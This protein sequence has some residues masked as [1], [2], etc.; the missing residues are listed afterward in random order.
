MLGCPNNAGPDQR[1]TRRRLRP[2]GRA[3]RRA[4]GRMARRR[5]ARGP[6]RRARH[7]RLRPR[8]TRSPAARRGVAARALRLAGRV[9]DRRRADGRLG[10]R[11]RPTTSCC[12]SGTAACGGSRCARCASRA[13]T[14][15]RATTSS[16]RCSIRSWPHWPR[17]G[18]GRR[19][20]SGGPPAIAS[21]RPSCWAGAAYGDRERA[22]RVGEAILAP[23]SPMHVP[24]RTASLDGAPVHVRS[25]CCLYHRV[26]GAEGARV[27]AAGLAAVAR[28]R[29]AVVA[30]TSFAR[31][32]EVNGAGRG[33]R[34]R[35]G[36][37]CAPRRASCERLGRNKGPTAH[38]L[39][40]A[41]RAFT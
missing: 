20:R 6:H 19:S 32:T 13:R 25:S 38:S 5:R 8:R 36:V 14:R 3:A 1:A 31:S 2:D 37:S 21:A 29:L 18:C 7:G 39:R 24:L 16:P 4:G 33:A 30:G 17:A 12:G 41:Q 10:A 34:S 27:P 22:R 28:R 23:P 15:G 11:P 26:P 35:A 40:P 9:A